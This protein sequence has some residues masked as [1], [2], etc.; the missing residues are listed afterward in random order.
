M[1][2]PLNLSKSIVTGQGANIPEH[3]IIRP[4]IDQ[5]YTGELF[6]ALEAAQADLAVAKADSAANKVALVTA[7]EALVTANAALVTANGAIALLAADIALI[8]AAV[9]VD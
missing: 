2:A 1:T 4:I 8:K 7:N 5:D 6:T 3:R 9:I